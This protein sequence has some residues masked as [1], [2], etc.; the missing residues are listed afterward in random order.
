[1]STTYRKFYIRCSWT[2]V[3]IIIMNL[4]CSNW[5]ERTNHVLSAA[6]PASA[7]SP[8]PCTSLL[9]AVSMAFDVFASMACTVETMM[10]TT[11][12]Q[13]IAWHMLFSGL[14]YWWPTSFQKHVGKVLQGSQCHCVSTLTGIFSFAFE[15]LLHQ[16]NVATKPV[17][18][19][20][21][22]HFY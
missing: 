4:K 8:V 9:S 22:H 6:I 16:V 14:G 10:S 3:V 20:P 2:A 18:H 17:F 19:S 15:G 5:I 12:V 11:T 1:M 21:C 7:R 13:Q